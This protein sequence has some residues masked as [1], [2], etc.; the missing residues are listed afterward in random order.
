MK[1]ILS[2][3]F[4][5]SVLAACNDNAT[6]EQEV[7]SLKQDIKTGW[8]STKAEVKEIKDSLRSKFDDDKDTTL[9]DTV[10]IK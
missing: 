2:V 3:L 9:K 4:L 7:D 8:D 10:K 6:A 5:I 1:R